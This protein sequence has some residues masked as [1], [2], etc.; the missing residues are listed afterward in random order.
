M[1][2]K[3]DKRQIN[4]MYMWRLLAEKI[5]TN[6]KLAAI[7]LEKIRNIDDTK[8]Y[9]DVIKEILSTHPKIEHLHYRT[10]RT[11]AKIAL[12]ELLNQEERQE[13]TTKAYKRGGRIRIKDLQKTNGVI[14]M[15]LWEK[16]LLEKIGSTPSEYKKGQVRN[17]QK[18]QH[19]LIQAGYPKRDKSTLYG[20]LKNFQNTVKQVISWKKNHEELAD[21]RKLYEKYYQPGKKLPLKQIVEEL[22]TIHKHNR[23]ENGIGKYIKENRKTAEEK[24]A[25]TS[26]L[27]SDEEKEFIREI[28]RNKEAYIVN[29]GRGM[30]WYNL[31][32]IFTEY[33]KAFPTRTRNK[34]GIKHQLFKQEKIIS[35][36]HQETFYHVI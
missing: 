13:L 17:I 32:K 14:S 22:N 9:S 15:E 33:Q 34:K 6:D 21:L 26:E 8:K 29:E 16:E 3:I 18:I 1:I 30:W 27:W 36:D 12:K 4:A 20:H 23:N 28:I 11:A 24:K 2:N 5:T 25:M 19:E 35:K 31:S 10:L 7:F